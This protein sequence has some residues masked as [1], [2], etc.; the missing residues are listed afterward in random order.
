MSRLRA[1]AD[2]FANFESHR[3][4]AAELYQRCVKEGS[5]V[6]L[7][8]F[9]EILITVQPPPM[10]LL[11]A[12]HDDLGGQ[13]HRL[14]LEAYNASLQG[15]GAASSPASEDTACVDPLGIT[16]LLQESLEE[17]LHALCI[18]QAH[19]AQADNPTR[20]TTPGIMSEVF[21]WVL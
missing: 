16:Q 20:R 12:I 19:S 1:T 2:P 4:L 3:R 11:H 21:T 14:R 15:G 8:N 7:Q 6:P 17:W 13:M 10:L 9:L 5:V 18:F